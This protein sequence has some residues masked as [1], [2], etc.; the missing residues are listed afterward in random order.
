MAYAS[1]SV[2]FGEQPSAAKWNILGTNDASFNNGT[3]LP[4]AG[5]VASYVATSETVASSTYSDLATVQSV[6]VT[7]G[8]NGLLLVSISCEMTHSVAN[9]LT[10][11]AFALSGANTLAAAIK[12][13]IGTQ[14]FTTGGYHATI[15]ATFL[16]TGLTPG[17]TTVTAKFN[18]TTSGTGT[19]DTRNLSAVPL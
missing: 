6:A 1:W 2:A 13:S 18:R 19:F 7:V 9:E 5:A 16:L 11:M 4:T 14:Q 8:S 3:G 17:S 10:S 15:G 12:Y